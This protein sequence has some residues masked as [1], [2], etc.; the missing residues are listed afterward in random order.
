MKN[1]MSF[2]IYNAILILG[3]VMI[4]HTPHIKASIDYYNGEATI[5]SSFHLVFPTESPK[6]IDLAN[7]EAIFTN[8]DFTYKIGFVSKCIGH[9]YTSSL[10]SNSWF[11][12]FYT[13]SEKP[14]TNNDLYLTHHILR[15]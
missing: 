13:L 14:L 1:K 15:L 12:L 7:K 5:S 9:T 3:L 4:L 11:H 2:H 10:H 6:Y 8:L